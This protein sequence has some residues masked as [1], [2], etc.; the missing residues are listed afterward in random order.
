MRVTAGGGYAIKAMMYIAGLGEGRVV[1]IRDIA[2]END[3]PMTSLCKIAQRLIRSGLLRGYRGAAGGV[4]LAHPAREINLL[5]IM[6]AVDGPFTRSRCF[7]GA[8]K[9][10]MGDKC[11]LRAVWVEAQRKQMEVLEDT[12]LVDLTAYVEQVEAL[13]E[14]PCS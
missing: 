10:P 1:R 11:R 2:A 13:L 5:Q 9:C 12:T 14:E 4:G 8:E 6:E 7:D 3:I